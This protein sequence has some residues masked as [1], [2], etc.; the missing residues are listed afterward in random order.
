MKAYMILLPACATLA[1]AACAY[2][3]GTPSGASLYRQNC[4]S[5]HGP[6]GAGD[7]ELA[8]TLPR[9]PADLRRLA[10][11]NGGVYPAEQVMA[12]IY[13]YRGKDLQGLMPEFAPLFD[14]P[15]V[16]WTAPDGRRIA[17]PAAL[18]AL[19]DHVRSLQVN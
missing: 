7:G 6:D 3:L 14:G 11:E 17:T 18:L 15:E 8:A 2:P 9:P 13:G 1:L 10:A 19:S 12:E 4:V 5:C 16:T